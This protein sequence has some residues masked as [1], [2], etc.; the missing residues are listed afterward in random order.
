MSSINIDSAYRTSS[1]VIIKNLEENRYAAWNKH[2][3]S[4]LFI[5]EDGK[6]LLEY[7]YTNNL[8]YKKFRGFKRILRKMIAHNLLS[9]EDSYKNNFF[10]AGEKNFNSIWDLI[11][12]SKNP[13][14][15]Y[16]SFVI[17]NQ[18]CNLNC[19]Y[20]IVKY[21][22]N[23][24]D[25]FVKKSNQKKIKRLLGC[26][27]QYLDSAKRTKSK[28]QINFNGG[29]ILLDWEVV[30]AAVNFAKQECPRERIK[31]SI[32]TNATLIND[33]IAAFLAGNKFDPIG[34]SFDGYEETHN[35]S[36]KYHN[37]KKSFDDVLRGLKILNKYLSRPIE[38]YQGTIIPAHHFRVEKLQEME[39]YGFKRARLGYNVLGITEEEARQMA[40]LYMQME[41]ESEKYAIKAN[42]GFIETYNL[43]LK[44]KKKKKAASLYCNALHTLAG[45]EINYNIDTEKVGHL[46]TYINDVQ[47]NLDEISDDIYHP[48]LFEKSKNTIRKR[49]DA[50]KRHCSDCEM[51]SIC[52]GGCVMTGLDSRNEINNAACVFQKETWQHF[53]E[54][55]SKLRSITD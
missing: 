34:I 26:L 5:N 30:K 19:P 9:T 4:V 11:D 10:A 29:E 46:C 32:N 23:K 42:D 14:F 22:Q 33:E 6:K 15:S 49:W 40:K 43:I 3:P 44:S 27:K 52:R 1:S 18:H 38:Y 17:I 48:L 31:F 21:N 2:A 35:I 8:P 28:K 20:C 45:A 51:V 13:D 41:I 53:L 55:N 36:R 47:V 54:F 50:L 16:M 25:R 7:M 37:N 39:K 24:K 12:R